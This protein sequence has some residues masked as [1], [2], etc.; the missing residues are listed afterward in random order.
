[1]GNENNIHLIPNKQ[2]DNTQ[3][4]LDILARIMPRQAALAKTMM[5]EYVEAGFDEDQALKLTA[6]SLFR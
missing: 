1:M 6:Y 4:A 5:E 3:L 2:V